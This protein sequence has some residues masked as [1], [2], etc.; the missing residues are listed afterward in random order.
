MPCYHPVVGYRSKAGRQ[1]NGAWPIVFR[2]QDGYT[3]LPVTIPCG[4]CVGCKQSYRQQWI[5]RLQHELQLHDKSAFLTLTYD[6]EHC[7]LSICKRDLQ[8]FF[9][10]YREET[11]ERIRYFACGEYGKEN[12]RP[13]YHAIVYGSDCGVQKTDIDEGPCSSDIVSNVWKYGFNYVGTVTPQS[14]AYVAGYVNKKIYDERRY[15]GKAK[16]FTIM[17]LGIGRGWLEQYADDVY[18]T[19]VCVMDGGR[20][21]RPPRYYNKKIEEAMPE[22]YLQMKINRRNML[23]IRDVQD[24]WLKEKADEHKIARI[25]RSYENERILNQR[26]QSRH[27]HTADTVG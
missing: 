3:D 16:P 4:R 1:S 19:D 8:L 26:Q 2:R 20:K 12:T 11:N 18:K 17:S 24:M 9:K 22:Q 27:I 13:H 7:P 5:V 6:E 21:Y 15:E 14:I 10:R 25:K 23:K